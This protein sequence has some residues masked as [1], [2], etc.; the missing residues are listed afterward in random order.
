ML[1]EEELKVIEEK[2]VTILED[3]KEILK[4][5]ATCG[6]EYYTAEQVKKS[7]EKNQKLTKNA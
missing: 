5:L 4:R 1:T 3:N 2:F 6:D 7:F